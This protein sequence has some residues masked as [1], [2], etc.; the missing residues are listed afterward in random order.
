MEMT[1]ELAARLERIDAYHQDRNGFVYGATY[2]ETVTWPDGKVEGLTHFVPRARMPAEDMEAV[3]A[4]VA[5]RARNPAPRPSFGW[6]GRGP[7]HDSTRVRGKGG[8]PPF[9]L[10]GGNE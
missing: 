9:T 8:S 2:R 5:W 4:L 1:A 6:F 7:S 10:P 3:D